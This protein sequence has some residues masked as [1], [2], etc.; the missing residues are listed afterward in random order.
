MRCFADE[1]FKYGGP[2]VDP[3]LLRLQFRLAFC[4]GFA[5]NLQYIEAEVL[6]EMPSKEEWRSVRDR[7]DPRV[8]G[9]W[10]VRCRTVAIL[11]L[12]RAHEALG[13]HSF[14]MEWVRQNPAVCRRPGV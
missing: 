9:R 7:W 12:I 1:Y 6:K 14:F 2:Q 3:N 4:A 5:G 10:N 8:M 13:M 11:Q